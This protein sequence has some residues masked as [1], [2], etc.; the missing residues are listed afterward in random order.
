MRAI[1]AENCRVPGPGEVRSLVRA[2]GAVCA[3]A[4]AQSGCLVLGRESYT[5]LGG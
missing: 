2:F 1:V 3:L 5:S 4:L